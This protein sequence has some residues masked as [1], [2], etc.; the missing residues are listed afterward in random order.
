MLASFNSGKGQVV[1][2]AWFGENVSIFIPT[3]PQTGG[4]RKSDNGAAHHTGGAPT[5]LPASLCSGRK[6]LVAEAAMGSA[7]ST[8]AADGV[9]APM[10]E[11]K[12]AATALDALAGAESQRTPAISAFNFADPLTHLVDGVHHALDLRHHHGHRTSRSQD[13]PRHSGEQPPLGPSTPGAV[14][15]VLRGGATGGA[16]T[17]VSHTGLDFLVFPSRAGRLRRSLTS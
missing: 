16:S 5:S 7:P 9:E 3:L 13:E 1:S 17:T 12:P 4:P 10:D 8:A 14:F 6:G 11:A 2:G 15:P